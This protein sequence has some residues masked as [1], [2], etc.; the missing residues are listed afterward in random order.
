MLP[1]VGGQRAR[2]GAANPKGKL[3]LVD[4]DCRDLELYRTLLQRQGYEVRCSNSFAEGQNCLDCDRFDCIVVSQGS[5]AFEGRTVLQHAV[6][7]DR[8]VPVLVLTRVAD[9]DCYLEAMQLGA[10]DYLE[11]PLAPMEVVHIVE[12][13]LKPYR[14]DS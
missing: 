9:T 1:N 14:A 13:Y 8:R 5:A 4:D 2:R 10:V 3:L 6:E 11:K 7:V 12:P